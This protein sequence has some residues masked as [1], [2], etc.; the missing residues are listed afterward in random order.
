MIQIR[1]SLEETARTE[2]AELLQETLVDLVDL[3]ILGK[4]AHWTV[5]GPRFRTLH[6]QL[7][8]MVDA[9]RRHAD[10]V[11]ERASAL[12][13]APDARAVRIAAQSGLP[14]LPAGWLTDETVVSH[15]VDAYAKLIDRMRVRI[16]R[17][18]RVDPVTQDLLIQIT[19]EL[20]KQS[21]MFQAEQSGIA[22]R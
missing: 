17:T 10:L 11:A 3:S 20:E 19:A 15:F 6:L 12:G 9:T 1:S 13:V 18:G 2:T 5:V 21:W 4:Q 7:D 16:D 8:E 22:H 14:Q